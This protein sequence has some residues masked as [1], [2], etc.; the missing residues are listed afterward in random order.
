MTEK[1]A[2]E[3]YLFRK[4]RPGHKVSTAMLSRQYN[5]SPK[6]IRDIWNRRTWAPETQHLWTD[7]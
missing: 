4:Y 6:A 2:V 5:V 7:D 1:E 3:I